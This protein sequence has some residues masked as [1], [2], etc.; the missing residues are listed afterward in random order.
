MKAVLSLLLGAAVLFSHGVNAQEVKLLQATSTIDFSFANFFKGDILVENLAYDKK[1]TVV[2]SINGEE[3]QEYEADYA[4]S[5]DNGLEL[6]RFSEMSPYSLSEYQFAIKY[7]VNGETFWD[8]NNHSDYLLT[9]VEGGRVENNFILH[10][11]FMIKNQKMNDW[12]RSRDGFYYMTGTLY[13]QN[14]GFEKQVD[15]V[16]TTDGWQTVETAEARYIDSNND[17]SSEEWSYSLK[18]EVANQH[19]EFAIRYRVNGDE[20]WDNNFGRNY[21][22]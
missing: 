18:S 4:E 17:G 11:D 14:L 7:E 8:N 13:L 20:Y 2:A 21:S 6:W 1:V 5:L 12:Y 9:K 10:S 3:W 19:V 16:Y 15:V 22:R